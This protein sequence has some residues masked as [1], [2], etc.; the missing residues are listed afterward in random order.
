MSRFFNTVSE[1]VK[2]L[3]YVHLKKENVSTPGNQARGELVFRT[4]QEAHLVNQK[5]IRLA[6]RRVTALE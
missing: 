4:E 5:L 6:E 2:S 1:M 3:P